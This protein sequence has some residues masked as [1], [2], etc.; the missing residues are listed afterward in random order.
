MS[1]PSIPLTQRTWETEFCKKPIVY[2]AFNIGLQSIL[3]QVSDKNTPAKDRI[4]AIRQIVGECIV[5]KDEIDVNEL[6]SF[7]LEL[8]FIKIRCISVSDEVRLNFKCTNEIGNKSCGTPIEVVIDLETVDINVDAEHKSVIDAGGFKL[9]L[10]YPTIQMAAD[11]ADLGDGVTAEHVIKEFLVYITQGEEVWQMSDFGN[12][13]KLEWV[14]GLGLDVQIDIMKNFF[15]NL[16]SIK[17]VKEFKCVTC[18]YDH[19]LEFNNLN[20][21]FM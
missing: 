17:I 1:L 14:Q 10:K 4:D 19:K 15:V 2:K 7:V 9:H 12:E 21:V 6:P 13:E 11:L 5:N 20:Q 16:P 18:G 8:L 3:L